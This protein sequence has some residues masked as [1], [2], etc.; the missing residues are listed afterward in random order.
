[1]PR[2]LLTCCPFRYP[3]G[4]VLRQLRYRPGDLAGVVAR[5]SVF[6]CLRSDRG[7]LVH[8]GGDQGEFC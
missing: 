3:F 6:R 1:M 7:Q 8:Y 4:D 5:G 2:P